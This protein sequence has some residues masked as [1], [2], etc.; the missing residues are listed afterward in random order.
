MP[1]EN[2]PGAPSPTPVDPAVPPV[3]T[4]PVDPAPAPATPPAPNPEPKTFPVEY[5]EQLR[6]ENADWRTKYQTTN[7][8][9]DGFKRA[10]M[11]KEQTLEADLKKYADDVVPG[12]NKRVQQLEVQVTASKLGII[13]PELASL[14]LDWKAVEGGKSVEIALNELLVLKPWLKQAPVQAAPVAPNVSAPPSQSSPATPPASNQP[15]SFTKSQIDAM[16]PS[17]R[18]RRLPEIEQAITEKR[19]DFTR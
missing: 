10:Q 6:R 15:Q 8:E 13:D 16:T 1:P 9:L 18:E 12:L 19:V 14:A 17:E 7:T 11:T 5:V 4:P 2:G 3:A